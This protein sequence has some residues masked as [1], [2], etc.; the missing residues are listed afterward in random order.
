MARTKSRR[1]PLALECLEQRDTPSSLA[2][3][4]LAPVPV[5]IQLAANPVDQVNT[6]AGALYTAGTAT[7]DTNRLGQLA[8][9]F[10]E[11][12]FLRHR[13]GNVY[14][15]VFGGGHEVIM[16]LQETFQP[17]TGATP[18][19]TFGHVQIRLIGV[20]SNGHVH[21]LAHGATDQTTGAAH[22]TLNGLAHL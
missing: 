3:H 18:A 13:H 8:G 21:D 5:T 15:D 9:S 16:H 22:L 14:L 11:H 17:H 1:C 12:L 2:H 20:T 19:S 7:V 4:P 6:P 10:T